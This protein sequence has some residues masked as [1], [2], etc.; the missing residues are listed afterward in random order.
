MDGVPPIALTLAD[1]FRQ[2][3]EVAGPERVMFGTDSSFFPRG[4]NRAVYDAQVSALDA[5]GVDDARLSAFSDGNFDRLF[6]A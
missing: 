3:L 2:A 4:W 1:V 6:P 5:A